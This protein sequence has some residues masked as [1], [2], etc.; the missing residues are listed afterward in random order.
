LTDSKGRAITATVILLIGAG[1]LI[2][3]LLTPWY[4]FTAS[5]SGVTVYDNFYAGLPTT[6]GTIR[7]SCSGGVECPSQTSYSAASLNN[8]GTIAETGF[9][10][11]IGGV[12]LGALAGILAFMF[13]NRRGL[14]SIILALAIL[15]VVLAIVAPAVFAVELPGAIS[16][17]HPGATGKGPWT[18]F[19]GSNST[20]L[21]PG[22][23]YST[24]WGPGLG[25]YLA[26][27]AFVIFCGG[28][29]LLF[30]NRRIDRDELPAPPA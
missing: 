5:G 15:A 2:G 28:L 11:L 23:A 25:W 12:I 6:N 24:T 8:T 21:G 14:G 17:D 16:K 30:R 3:S 27:G 22:A 29:F 20:T 18:S 4:T 19:F 26:I 1:V 9:F 10:L 13:R 7:Y